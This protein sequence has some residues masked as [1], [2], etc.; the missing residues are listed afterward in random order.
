MSQQMISRTCAHCGRELQV[1][2]EL[3]EFACLYCGQRNVVASAQSAQSAVRADPADLEYVRAH[4]FDVI[5][6]H[7]EYF[8][9]ITRDAYE[10]SF[11]RYRES[12]KPIFKAMNRYVCAKPMERETLLR[13]FAAQFVSDWE[14]YHSGMS[15][16]KSNRKRFDNKMIL[17]LFTVPAIRD[18]NLPVGEDFCRELH[19]AFLAKYP[20]QPFELAT[21]EQISGGF[22]KRKLCFI[23]TAVCEQQ[24]K[25]DDCPELTAFRRFRD[26]WLR[27]TPEGEALVEEYYRLAPS[28]VLAMTYADDKA[29]VCQTLRRDY[30]EPCYED[31]GHN[32]PARCRDRYVAMVHMLQARYGM[33]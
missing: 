30:L 14:D 8:D 9:K 3:T 15:R 22:R 2:Q 11:H 21:Y 23:T 32:R 7:P 16:L 25:P 6:S 5:R 10:G 31:L 33:Q 29:G 28:I 13:D 18:L 27:A 17:A 20:D 1:P 24:G 4:L 19:T 12:I 26:G